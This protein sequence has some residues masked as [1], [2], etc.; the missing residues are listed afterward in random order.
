MLKTLLSFLPPP[1]SLSRLFTLLIFLS[2]KQALMMVIS[3]EIM[4]MFRK[5]EEES[6]GLELFFS[7]LA[8]SLSSWMG[9][10]AGG[11]G[12]LFWH[13]GFLCRHNWYASRQLIPEEHCVLGLSVWFAEFIAEHRSC[14]LGRLEK[15]RDDTVVCILISF[16]ILKSLNLDVLQGATL[17]YVCFFFLSLGEDHCFWGFLV[18]I[19]YFFQGALPQLLGWVLIRVTSSGE[20]L[21]ILPFIVKIDVYTQM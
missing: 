15:T 7:D 10:V 3:L 14:A 13:C 5:V 6:R 8:C 11:I 12:T 19:C 21:F 20:I 17:T 4:A 18:Y 1:Y 16:T 2:G 9:T